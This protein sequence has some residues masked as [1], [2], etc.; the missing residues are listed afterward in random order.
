MNSGGLIYDKY[1][2]FRV[3]NDKYNDYDKYNDSGGGMC[4]LGWW[5]AV[6]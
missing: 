6:F 5:S 3:K 2:D 4:V 1:N